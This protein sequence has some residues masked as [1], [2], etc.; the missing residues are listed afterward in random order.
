MCGRFVIELT[1]ETV[2]AA[3]H[4]PSVPDLPARYNVAPTQLIPVIRSAADGRRD[5][6]SLLWGL[7]PS[8]AKEP[9][10]GLINARSETAG[11]KPSFRQSLRQRRCIVISSGF[12][13]WRRTEKG[14]QPYYIRPLAEGL[15]PFAG[16]WDAWRA[17][18][19]TVLETCAILTTAANPLVASIHDRMPVILHPDE[20]SLWLDRSIH[21]AGVLKPLFA[22]Y[23]AGLLTSSPVSTLVNDP[24]HDS[25]ACLEPPAP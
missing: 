7:I 4:L 18:D 14:K 17:P 9:G 21:E 13:E 19:G 25:P 15:L 1:P 5:L 10:E 22:P 16:I 2:T 24:S 23:P 8:W 20:F 12:Y 6:S 11:E 3:F